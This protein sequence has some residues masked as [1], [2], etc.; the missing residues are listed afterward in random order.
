MKVFQKKN[1]IEAM[2]PKNAEMKSK[3]VCQ[4]KMVR[5]ERKL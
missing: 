5:R 4:I 2:N 3:D 1:N